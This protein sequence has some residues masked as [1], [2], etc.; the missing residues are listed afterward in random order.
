MNQRYRRYKL[1]V[2]V[3]NVIYH[4]RTYQ[5]RIVVGESV[6]Q[7]IHKHFNMEFQYLF[8]GSE[9]IESNT[10]QSAM[11]ICAGVCAVIPKGVYH[12]VQADSVD[13]LCFGLTI[14]YNDN[15]ENPNASDYRRLY[16]V[17]HQLQKI[18][19]VSD[20]ELT[21]MMEQY[22][23]LSERNDLFLSSQKGLLLLCIAL[24][25]MDLMQA[26]LPEE[27][28][29]RGDKTDI[30]S[31]NRKQLIEEYICDRFA[32][33]E[34]IVGL[35]KLLYLSERQTRRLVQK[36]FGADY[37]QLI[38]QERMKVADILLR[39]TPQTLEQI[40]QQVGY[41]SYSGFYLAYLRFYG[42]SPEVVRKQLKQNSKQQNGE[43]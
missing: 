4:I 16:A 1:S 29:I 36:E 21:Q 24:R 26:L 28:R 8:A 43:E 40:A 14:E 38:I 17:Y 19:I 18:E 42:I 33:P 25:L 3:Q 23:E 20:R 39:K 5:D 27:A 13:R 9:T 22:R 2:A 31:I 32:S 15:C 6:N 11:V 41:Q 35:S 37:K 10:D 12:G 30:V 34:G 7:L